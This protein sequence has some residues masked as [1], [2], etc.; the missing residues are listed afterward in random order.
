[1]AQ[2]I[3]RNNHYYP[4][5]YCTGPRTVNVLP[6]PTSLSKL[7]VP[8]SSF[9]KRLE[10]DSPTPVLLPHRRCPSPDCICRILP[11]AP[12]SVDEV[13]VVVPVQEGEVVPVRSYVVA[14][15][16]RNQGVTSEP[17]ERSRLRREQGEGL[18][19]TGPPQESYARRSIY[20]HSG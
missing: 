11:T 9:T 14:P 7:T 3:R 8:P 16:A 13:H 5:S 18:I 17:G 2:G 10:I 20:A 4:P 6:L 15:G 12:E 19:D 1:V